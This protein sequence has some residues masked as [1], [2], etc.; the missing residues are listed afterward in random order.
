MKNNMTNVIYLLKIKYL[1]IL[2]NIYYYN[3]CTFNILIA[4]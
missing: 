3:I 2:G 4:I 1:A